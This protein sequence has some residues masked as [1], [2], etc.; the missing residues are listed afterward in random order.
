MSWRSSFSASPSPALAVTIS[1]GSPS[2]QRQRE[3]ADPPVVVRRAV[4][5]LRAVA[6]EDA[7]GHRGPGEAGADV[8]GE[9]GS[10]GAVGQ[11]TDGAVRERDAHRAADASYVDAHGPRERVRL[12]R[13]VGDGQRD[14]VVAGRGVR[15]RRV[16]LGRRGVVAEVPAPGDDLPVGVGRRVGERHRAL[17]GEAP[18]EVRDRRP[19]EIRVAHRRERARPAEPPERDHA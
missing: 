9:V 17:R 6:V 16:A 4:A 11:F 12:A 14:R 8:G 13:V 10:G 15:V 3:V 19:A 2:T 5:L 18:A 7:D 1:T